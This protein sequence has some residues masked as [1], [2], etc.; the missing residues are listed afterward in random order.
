MSLKKGEGLIFVCKYCACL[1]NTILHSPPRIFGYFGRVSSPFYG[2]FPLD[3]W[4]W[5]DYVIYNIYSWPGMTCLN[6]M[7]NMVQ[8]QCSSQVVPYC[9][10]KFY[11][12]QCSSMIEP[13]TSSI[14]TIGNHVRF[15]F[16]W[17]GIEKFHL[18]L[19]RKKNDWRL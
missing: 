4:V 17:R 6:H 8:W 12:K 15:I 5:Y 13:T 3:I 16:A 10:G 18:F 11:F 1:F 7:Q 2:T 9:I 14:W 19:C